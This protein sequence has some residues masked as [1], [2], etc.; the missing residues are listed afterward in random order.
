LL[1]NSSASNVES[2]EETDNINNVDGV[3]L[4]LRITRINKETS[5][6]TDEVL[7]LEEINDSLEHQIKLIQKKLYVFLVIFKV[8]LNFKISKRKI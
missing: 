2:S 3:D 7:R 6:L 4:K 5:T 8:P 1:Y